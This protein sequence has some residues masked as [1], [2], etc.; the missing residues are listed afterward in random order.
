MNMSAI[1]IRKIFHQLRVLIILLTHWYSCKMDH[2]I[3]YNNHPLYKTR[4]GSRDIIQQP[5]TI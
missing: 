5:P 3:L 1:V 4:N 2:V